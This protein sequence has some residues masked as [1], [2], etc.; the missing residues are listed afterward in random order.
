MDILNI[1]Y[2]LTST[3][4]HT[5]LKTQHTVIF[6]FYFQRD[7]S[8]VQSPTS[9]HCLHAEQ[10]TFR[11]GRG[12]TTFDLHRLQGHSPDKENKWVW[13]S[14]PALEVWC[15][16]GLRSCVLCRPS[17][18]GDHSGQQGRCLHLRHCKHL[19]DRPT[20]RFIMIH[21]QPWN[22]HFYASNGHALSRD[23]CDLWT[24]F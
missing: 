22:N 6:H 21:I 2:C 9:A 15:G 23:I 11:R 17:W 20:S 13:Q 4:F 24:H 14:S 10:R 7:P 8:Q 16:D 1:S 19:Q 18:Q 5:W 3:F 12:G